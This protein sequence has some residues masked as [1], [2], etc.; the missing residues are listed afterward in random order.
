MNNIPIYV[1]VNKLNS[2]GLFHLITKFEKEDINDYYFVC[3][4][5]TY[6][7]FS[8]KDVYGRHFIY[9][10]GNSIEYG[11][12]WKRHVA[13]NDALEKDYNQILM[14]DD[15]VDFVT[16]NMTIRNAIRIFDTHLTEFN[17]KVATRIRE[18]GE[19][20]TK[21][22]RIATVCGA[23]KNTE[24]RSRSQSSLRSRVLRS[25][26][27]KLFL[28]NIKFLNGV[29]FDPILT[30]F[31]EDM[32]F[33]KELENNEREILKTYDVIIDKNQIIENSRFTIGM[34]V[35]QNI[36]IMF[37]RYMKYED[38]DEFFLGKVDILKTNFFTLIKPVSNT[39]ETFPYITKFN[40][41]VEFADGQSQLYEASPLFADPERNYSYA[42]EC[43]IDDRGTILTCG[44]LFEKED[45]I[46]EKHLTICDIGTKDTYSKTPLTIQQRVTK[47][48]H[49]FQCPD[50]YFK[51][52][53]HQMIGNISSLPINKYY[54][55][56]Y[57]FFISS[58]LLQCS[59]Q[60]FGEF[61]DD[62]SNQSKTVEDIATYFVYNTDLCYIN[63]V[64]QVLARKYHFVPVI[65]EIDEALTLIK[66]RCS[67]SQRC[68]LPKTLR[69]TTRQSTRMLSL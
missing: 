3:D 58:F 66:Q 21:D 52:Y 42:S 13:I 60:T 29:N 56:W 61:S 38:L 23:V 30:R 5:N 45:R 51:K 7:R 11:I 44:S 69:R 28:I 15:N 24:V 22:I 12:G 50:I 54:E 14:M 33:F 26:P 9:G 2:S 34:Q 55:N 35:M 39:F 20:N 40:A 48:N 57:I 65:R 36:Y 43:Y 6:N 27:Q 41:F 18:F 68:T 8:E 16:K 49:P 1:I 31:G 67:K 53:G 63:N 59:P 32:L 64:I 37:E 47:D 10:N 46:P 4:T 17:T 25:A 62:Q 19:I